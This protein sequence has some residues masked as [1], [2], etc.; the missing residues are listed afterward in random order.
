MYF[1]LTF[2]IGAIYDIQIEVL[3]NSSGIRD[4]E[5]TTANNSATINGYGTF[6]MTF[7]ATLAQ[8]D[9]LELQVLQAKVASAITLV[10]GAAYSHFGIEY[11]GTN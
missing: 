7:K 1:N 3:N 2:E 11:E 6:G 5:I 9:V 10:G 4:Y 8:D